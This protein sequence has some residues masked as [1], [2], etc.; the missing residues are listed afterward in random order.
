[1]PVSALYGGKSQALRKLTLALFKDSANPALV[2][3]DEAARGI[4]VDGIS[5]VVHVEVPQDHKDYL[6]RSG[7][8]ASAGELG[9]VV[10]LTTSKQQMSVSGLNSRAGVTPK[11]V[12]VTSLSSGLM[13]ITGAEETAGIPCVAPIVENK[14]GGGLNRGTRKPRPNSAQ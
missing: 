6:Y 13:R 1:M 4:Q 14:G 9:A 3:T 11:S 5:L 2:A 8:K 12:S 10:T 7:R